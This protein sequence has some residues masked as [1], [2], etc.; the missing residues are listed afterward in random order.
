MAYEA[1]T[2]STQGRGSN[3][4]DERAAEAA[5]HI[6]QVD[7]TLAKEV[8][9]SLAEL[10]T[11]EGMPKPQVEGCVPEVSVIDQDSVAAIIEH[12]RGVANYCDLAVLDFASFTNPG[13]GYDRGAWAQEEALCA[14]STLF[15]VLREQKAW[16]SQNRTRNINCELYRNRALVVPKVRFDRER[17]H[18]YADVIV[19][20]APNARR[21]REN[22]RIDDETLVKFMRDRIR[23]V[24]AIADDLGHEKLVL[25]AFGCGVFGWDASQVA[26]L[27]LEELASGKHAAKQ[28]FF[29][30]PR[31]RFDEN[32]LRFE[33]A[34]AC[35]PE[36]NPEPYVK[37]ADRPKVVEHVEEDE[38]DE[39]DWRKYL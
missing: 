13:G 24:L 3:R 14:E 37:L 1:R 16:Y 9:R 22:Y 23:F 20:A 33:H 8:E 29:A 31:T 7:A 12:G 39:D 11:Y 26:Q 6:A 18:G 28:V 38:E 5:K 34:F 21:A 4:R 10:R 36:A 17:Y 30:V 15:N 27:F 32:F 19:A 2:Q 25:G 35:F